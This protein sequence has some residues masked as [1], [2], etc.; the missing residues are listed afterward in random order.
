M[1]IMAIDDE[2]NS[3]SVLTTAIKEAAPD[4]IIDSFIF[5]KDALEK[6]KEVKYDVVFSDIKMPELDGIEF[7]KM[8][9]KTNEHINIIYVTGHDSYLIPALNIHASGYLFKPVMSEDIKEALDNLIFPI[10][11]KKPKVYINTFGHFE[12]YVNDKIVHFS[13]SKSKELLAY[14]VDR[15]GCSVTK[16]ELMA[17]LFADDYSKKAQDYFNKIVQSLVNT[18][19]ENGIEDIMIKEFNSYAINK[20]LFTCDSY[21]FL[22]GNIEAINKF[23]GEYMH[24]Y[25]W[26]EVSIEKFFR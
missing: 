1:R 17:I 3:L 10:D 21:E 18:L 15:S 25:S 20:N 4:S 9:K 16:K 7:V 24:Q 6:A 8:L 2:V 26:S 12:I 13:R 14:L 22:N 23:R 5:T 11:N 19:K